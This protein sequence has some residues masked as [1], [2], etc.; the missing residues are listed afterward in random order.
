MTFR[1]IIGWKMLWYH[2]QSDDREPEWSSLIVYSSIQRMFVDFWSGG[3]NRK[4]GKSEFNWY[5]FVV[6]SVII[7]VTPFFGS[8]WQSV[9]MY[10]WAISLQIL[11][12]IPIHDDIQQSH[13]IHWLNVWDGA[14]K[15]YWLTGIPRCESWVGLSDVHWLSKMIW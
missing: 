9:S 2:R 10:L 12:L 14:T 7:R 4:A 3:R 1:S 6:R 13:S 15:Q 8:W 11:L 5:L